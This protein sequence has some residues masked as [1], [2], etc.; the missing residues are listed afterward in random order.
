MN[1]KPLTDTIN[2]VLQAGMEPMDPA[3]YIQGMQAVMTPNVTSTPQ[4]QS[5]IWFIKYITAGPLYIWW[6]AKTKWKLS[7]DFNIS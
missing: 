2:A 5:F 6:L 4:I 7:T 1:I 3:Q